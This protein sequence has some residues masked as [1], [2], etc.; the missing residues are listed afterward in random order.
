M[1]TRRWWVKIRLFCLCLLLRGWRWLPASVCHSTFIVKYLHMRKSMFLLVAKMTITNESQKLL[2]SCRERGNEI[3]GRDR[4]FS[5]KSFY[6]VTNSRRVEK[7]IFFVLFLW[8]QFAS[9]SMNESHLKMLTSESTEKSTKKVII[10]KIY[11]FNERE[12][13]FCIFFQFR[14]S[15]ILPCHYQFLIVYT[16]SS[17]KWWWWDN[18]RWRWW[19]FSAQLVEARW[20]SDSLCVDIIQFE[21]FRRRHRKTE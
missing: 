21:H 8:I 19:R 3:R 20:N 5:A 13:F 14:C 7:F 17:R 6:A 2:R 1:T 4:D 10:V 11:W 15:F 16:R 9:L 12:F 18:N